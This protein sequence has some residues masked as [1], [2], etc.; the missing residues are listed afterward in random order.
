MNGKIPCLCASTGPWKKYAASPR[1]KIMKKTISQLLQE[2]KTLQLTPHEKAASLHIIQ[3]HMAR[4]P[5][6]QI[7]FF[8]AINLVRSS[9]FAGLAIALLA[10][11][12]VSQAAQ[13]TLPGAILYP[14][15]SL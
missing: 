10:G 11:A 3:T 14:V 13:K 6:K 2:A 8:A 1:K 15:K 4:Y 9:A 12:G 5:R 7:S